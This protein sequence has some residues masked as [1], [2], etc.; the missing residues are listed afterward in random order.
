MK[1][2]RLRRCRPSSRDA[3][4]RNV[5]IRNQHSF[6]V[7]KLV[8]WAVFLPSGTLSM[9]LAGDTHTIQTGLFLVLRHE[10][11]IFEEF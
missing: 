7:K 1:A 11:W 2:I 4:A 9:D 6:E 10:L 5:G 3:V 8:G